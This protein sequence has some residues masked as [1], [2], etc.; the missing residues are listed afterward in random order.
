MFIIN[1]FLAPFSSAKNLTRI[2]RFS[3]N[4]RRKNLNSAVSAVLKY[5]PATNSAVRAENPLPLIRFVQTAAKKSRSA[6]LS[7]A[8]AALK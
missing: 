4:A 2:L 5:L 7:A 1:F 3:D 8:N 6:T